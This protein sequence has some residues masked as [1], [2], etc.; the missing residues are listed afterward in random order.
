MAGVM[1]TCE[2]GSWGAVLSGTTWLWL[3]CIRVVTFCFLVCVPVQLRCT[4]VGVGCPGRPA[5]QCL[6]GV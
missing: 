2:L 6:R 3:C 4:V 5:L 1:A